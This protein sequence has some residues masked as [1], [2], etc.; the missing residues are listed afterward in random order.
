MNKTIPDPVQ[1]AYDPLV[2]YLD[3][4][5]GPSLSNETMREAVRSNIQKSKL[6][7]NCFCKIREHASKFESDFFREMDTL[8]VKSPDVLTRVSDYIPEIEQMVL[9]IIENGY[10]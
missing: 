3:A 9:K 7:T 2:E 8:N 5:H 6:R 1:F 4:L 10:A